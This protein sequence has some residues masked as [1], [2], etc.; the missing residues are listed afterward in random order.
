MIEATR[1]YS[2][3]PVKSRKNSK[4]VSFNLSAMSHPV[5]SDNMLKSLSA[6]DLTIDSNDENPYVSSR[7]STMPNRIL[8]RSIT[9]YTKKS[10]LYEINH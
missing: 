4:K 3:D 9:E 2:P 10:V 8:S 1:T 7:K 5:K 6:P